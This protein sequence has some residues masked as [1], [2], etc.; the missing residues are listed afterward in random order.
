[1]GGGSNR[2]EKSLGAGRQAKASLVRR[3]NSPVVAQSTETR[4]NPSVTRESKKPSLSKSEKGV[5]AASR[6]IIRQTKMNSNRELFLRMSDL[7]ME[8]HS[9]I[10]VF[11]IG[12]NEFCHIANSML[13]E[14]GN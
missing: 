1:M 11:A 8:Q 12:T 5:S 13:V 10:K 6:Q 14:D 4:I 7:L 2:Y 3:K 9:D